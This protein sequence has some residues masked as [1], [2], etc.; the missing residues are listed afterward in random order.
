MFGTTMIPQYREYENKKLS[1]YVLTI[2]VPKWYYNGT[3][4]IWLT[5]TYKGEI[6][7]S[8]TK[9][10]SNNEVYGTMKL[11]FSKEMKSKSEELGYL[12]AGYELNTDRF[13]HV[14]VLMTDI[15]GKVH[16]VKIHDW[17]IELDNYFNENNG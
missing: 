2:L 1:N 6:K 9:A 12:E 8:I 16:S 15:H 11:A 13:V 10:Q 5:I 14:E 4:L 3:K 17:D 7:M